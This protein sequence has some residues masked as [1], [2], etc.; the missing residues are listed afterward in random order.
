MKIIILLEVRWIFRLIFNIPSTC[1]SIYSLKYMWLSGDGVQ[2]QSSGPHLSWLAGHHAEIYYYA[3]AE[4]MTDDLLWVWL[5]VEWWATV[6]TDLKL[7]QWPVYFSEHCWPWSYSTGIVY[8]LGGKK[9]RHFSY[10][11]ILFIRYGSD[12]PVDRGVWIIE[13]GQYF[14]SL[15]KGYRIIRKTEFLEV[16]YVLTSD[17]PKETILSA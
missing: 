14:Q 15:G 16:Q 8:I 3:C 17:L 13:V 11:D 6:S 7:P 5:H 2:P 9:C 12:Q 4:G 10:L 1:V